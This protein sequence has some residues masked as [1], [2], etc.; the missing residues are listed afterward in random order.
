MKTLL[1][2]AAIVA[3]LGAALPAAAQTWNGVHGQ[4]FRNDSG[5]E[6]RI[7][8]GVRNGALTPSEARSLNRQLED[9]RRLE[10][11]YSRNGL[12]D[13]EARELDRRYGSLESRV[14]AELRDHDNRFD[15]DRFGSGYGRGGFGYR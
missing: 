1:T 4:G 7:D 9:V 14:R 12:N 11:Q 6:A 3:T 5:I 10:W 2:A 8:R 13:R 15:R